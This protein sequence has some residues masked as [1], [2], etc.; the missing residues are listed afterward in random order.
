MSRFRTVTS[1][2]S[3][4][5]RVVLTVAALLVLVVY[6]LDF[7]VRAVVVRESF[8]D[9][10]DRYYL[11]SP[12]V[13]Q[14]AS[15]GYRE[16]AADLVWVATIQHASDRRPVAGR[17]FPWLER[18]LDSVIALNPYMLK[19][20]LWADGTITY[21]RGRL[22]N[23]EWRRSIHYLELGQRR[24]P[25]NWEILFKLASAYTELR[26]RD[27]QKRSAWMRRAADYLW[28]AH[29]VGGGPSWLG[30]LAAR[31]WSDEGQW[32]LAYRRTLEELKATED[33]SVRREM[34]DRLATLL[35]RT[36]GG[37]TLVEGLARIGGLAVGSPNAPGLL[38]VAEAVWRERRERESLRRVQAVESQ[39][40]AFDRDHHRCLPYGSADLFALLGPCRVVAR[41]PGEREEVW[42]GKPVLPPPPAEESTS[43][44]G[45]RPVPVR[46]VPVRP[47][48]ATPRVPPARP[49]AHRANRAPHGEAPR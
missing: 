24:F 8:P 23:E 14:V 13:L 47:V 42:R 5:S 45:M 46:A 44:S 18:Y 16:A 30:S 40:A 36:S 17:V 28:K 34:S 4:G 3:E 39:K 29:L 41:D 2:L 6:M 27:P 15:L 31:Y 35:T 38:L 20:Y 26:T 49:A 33:P 11:P 25:R 1:H 21:A 43:P 7:R 48:A 22:N 9:A 19:L 32:L 10:A 37:H 12:S